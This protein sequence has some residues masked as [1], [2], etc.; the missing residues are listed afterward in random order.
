[1]TS[2]SVVGGD[3]ARP[4][5]AVMLALA[6]GAILVP[7]NTTMLA[8]ALPGI[9][10]EFD[11]GANEV[12]SLVTLYLGAVAIALPVSGALA[13]RF[14]HR[15]T[16]VVGVLAFGAASLAAALGDVFPLLQGA[17]LLQAISGALV[18]T[19]SVAIIREIAPPERRGEA[20]G[21]F[22]LLTSTSAA[23]GPFVG[24]VLIGAFTWRS[25]FYV[26][27]PIAV[28]SAVA[29]WNL[30]P[31]EPKH[32]PATGPRSIDVPGLVVLGTLIAAIL[33][34]LRVGPAGIGL[35]ALVA[36]IPLVAAFLVV[37]LRTPRPAVDPRLFRSPAFASAAAGIFGTTVVLHGSFILVP[38][39]VESLLGASATASGIVLLG[40]AGV[41]ALV[42]P[43][44]GRASD[45]LGRR[46]LA[47]AGSLITALGIAALAV[48]MALVTTTPLP[49]VLAALAVVLG[50]VGLGMGLSGAPR[51]TAALEAVP[52]G[53]AGMGAGTYLTAR[54]L[55]GLVGASLAGAVLQGQVTVSGMSLG[56]AILALAGLGVVAVS[57]GLPGRPKQESAPSPSIP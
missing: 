13:D 47:A 41:G 51:Q 35:A 53:R 5:S 48:G 49:I 40:V 52:T 19:S 55:G 32:D 25:I 44:G 7:L 14:G 29:V 50:V 2:G 21:R 12:A 33:A 23:V 8:V 38:L 20:F 16:F 39:L 22:D 17:R 11:L 10:D 15:R 9:M 28:A 57:L 6:G 42:A 30:L 31:G 18:S 1:V 27:A 37:E 45:R 36:I 54:Y 43:W 34:A 4:F 24:G 46:R 26:C 56:F 3:E